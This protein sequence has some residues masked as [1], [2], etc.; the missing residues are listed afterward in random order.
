MQDAND[1]HASVLEF[2]EEDDVLTGRISFNARSYIIIMPSQFFR[3]IC[4]LTTICEKIVIVCVCLLRRPSIAGVIPDIIKVSSS[5]SSGVRFSS[6][7][8][9]VNSLRV[10]IPAIC[11]PFLRSVKI[12][13][14]RIYT[15][16][17]EMV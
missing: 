16:P 4:H 6:E 3:F 8:I 7:R 5:F 2:P 10:K 11:S 17:G 14:L 15:P 1:T 12:D 9:L 13:R